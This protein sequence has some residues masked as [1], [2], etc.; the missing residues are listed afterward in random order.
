MRQV[1]DVRTETSRSKEATLWQQ[2]SM[3][4]YH[5]FVKEGVD[6]KQGLQL[7]SMIQTVVLMALPKKQEHNP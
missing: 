5:S 2:V 6:V 7:Q 4:T 3:W 1:L